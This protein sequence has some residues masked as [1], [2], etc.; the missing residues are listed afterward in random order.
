MSG[1]LIFKNRAIA[2]T[3]DEI[4]AAIERARNVIKKCALCFKECSEQENSEKIVIAALPAG[5]TGVTVS[6]VYK[7]KSA[8]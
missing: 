2:E 4:D 8:H 6:A 1:E 3:P 7:R 5:H